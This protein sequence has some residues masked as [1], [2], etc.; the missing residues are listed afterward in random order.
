VPRLWCLQPVR[1]TLRHRTWGPA[2]EIDGLANVQ[3]KL[4]DL[5]GREL[6][7]ELINLHIEACVRQSL[8]I[9]GPVSADVVIL[10]EDAASLARIGDARVFQR[11]FARAIDRDLK[12]C[13]AIPAQHAKDF[14]HRTPV[15]LNIYENVIADDHVEGL[16][17]E[18]YIGHIH[19]PHRQVR[20]IVDR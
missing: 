20:V 19:A 3:T 1:Y 5:R 13:P 9:V 2:A 16:I 7:H 10:T 8:E 18:V 15:V 14:S 6:L 17:G 4:F 11:A 12:E